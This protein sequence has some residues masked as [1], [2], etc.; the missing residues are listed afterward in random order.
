M[1]N[2]SNKFDFFLFF[3]IIDQFNNESVHFTIIIINNSDWRCLVNINNKFDTWR[4]SN[5]INRSI[6]LYTMERYGCSDRFSFITSF[7]SWSKWTNHCRTISNCCSLHVNENYFEKLISSRIFLLSSAGVGRTGT[8]IAI[9]AMID[10]IEH[11]KKVDIFN[12]VLQMRRERNLMVQT[13][14]SREEKNEIFS[15]FIV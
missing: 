9:D 7:N 4:W 5:S 11:E 2:S 13:V 12:F 3:F 8:Y 6:S 15:T 1:K 14:V 10:K